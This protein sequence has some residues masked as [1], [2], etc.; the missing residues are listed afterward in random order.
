MTRSEHSRSGLR[1]MEW[2]KDSINETRESCL[3]R[4]A[5]DDQLIVTAVLLPAAFACT[6]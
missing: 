4:A 6:D 2:K 1:G 3:P 5:T